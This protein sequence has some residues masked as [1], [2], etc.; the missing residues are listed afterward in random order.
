[1][2]VSGD[3]MSTESNHP[4]SAEDPSASRPEASDPDAFRTTALAI[5]AEVA[6]VIVGQRDAVR[7]VLICLIAGGHA[8][9]EGVPGVGKTSVARAF[10][11]ALGLSN[12]RVQ[13]TP[14]L[15]PADI[16]G[17][18]VLSGDPATGLR[19]RFEPGPIFTNL[20]L[21]DEI[22]RASP[23]TQSAL[24]EA[25]QERTVTVAGTSHP[26][27]HPFSVLAT[28]NPIELQGTYPLPEAQLDRFLLKLRFGYPDLEELNA[29]V[30]DAPQLSTDALEPVADGVQLEAMNVLARQVPAASEVV[31]YASRLLLSLQPSADADEAVREYVRLGPSPRG[32]QAL[33]LAGRI[34]ALLDGRHNLAIEDIHAVALPALSHRLVLNFDAERDGVEA[35][36]VVTAALQ[37]LDARG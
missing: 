33:T 32:G 1:M 37:R 25:M 27:P 11:A 22:N 5:E 21:A 29:I 20:L 3:L 14:D 23:R 36:A 15:L 6:K 35:D 18:T 10:A 8:L 17:T 19:G 7:G 31:A 30:V 34:A 26:L 28:Q 9:L 4:S 13:F 12:N 2:T 16:T 24:L